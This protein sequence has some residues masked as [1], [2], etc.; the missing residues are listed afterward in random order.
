MEEEDLTACVRMSLAIDLYE[1]TWEM[2]IADQGGGQP[3][4]VHPYLH[5]AL[6]DLE[7]ERGARLLLA[8]EH[9]RQPRRARQFRRSGVWSSLRGDGTPGRGETPRRDAGGGEPSDGAHTGK[10]RSENPRGGEA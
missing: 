8:R 1:D 10:Q 3:E 2:R 5:Q 6:P 9:A 7:D 4:D